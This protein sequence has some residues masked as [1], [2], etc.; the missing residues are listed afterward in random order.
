MCSKSAECVAALRGWCCDVAF[1]HTRYIRVHAQTH[2][3]RSHTTPHKHVCAWMYMCTH[4]YSHLCTHAHTHIHIYVCTHT[5]HVVFTK[6]VYSGYMHRLPPTCMH[7][8]TYPHAHRYPYAYTHTLAHTGSTSTHVC[9][10]TC[11]HWV[12]VAADR[13]PATTT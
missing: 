7:T 12:P 3:S 6:K 8:H 4:R 5:A 13:A 10:R 1:P 11:T 2:V 9:T